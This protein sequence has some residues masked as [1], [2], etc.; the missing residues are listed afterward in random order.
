[1][2]NYDDALPL[3]EEQLSIFREQQGLEHVETLAAESFV[4]I[5]LWGIGELSAARDLFTHIRDV[6]EKTKGPDFE[7]TEFARGMISKL[8]ARIQEEES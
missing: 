6:F 4:A 1:M 3:R 7:T 5:D 8:D 2:G